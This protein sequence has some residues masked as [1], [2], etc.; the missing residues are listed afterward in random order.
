VNLIRGW[1]PHLLPLVWG[2]VATL[3]WDRDRRTAGWVPITLRGLLND[4]KVRAELG[5]IIADV[6]RYANLSPE[7]RRK[8]ALDL[9]RA[10]LSAR[11]IPITES[12]LA[13]L[14]EL[15][16]GHLKRTHPGAIAPAPH[17]F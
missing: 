11:G 17:A 14:I 5:Q 15:L 13:T 12:E 1:L 10:A 3:L 7:E 6:A 4:P 2:F 8:L 16:Y 9:I